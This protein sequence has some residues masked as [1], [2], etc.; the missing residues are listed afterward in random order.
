MSEPTAMELLNAINGL[1]NRLDARLAVMES[2]LTELRADNKD[3]ENRVRVVEQRTNLIDRVNALDEKI[4]R[5]RIDQ[6]N[7]IK[8]IESR[9]TQHDA[10]FS[11]A[12][13]R[14]GE[15]TI[16]LGAVKERIDASAPPKAHPVAWAAVV[17][18][19]LAIVVT[20]VSV[21]LANS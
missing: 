12:N 19:A 6:A 14:I 16:G 17:L 9:V 5:Q 7:A 8:A 20:V 13:E 2:Q 1:G 4:E 3:L 10:A 21:V 15:N 18:S 11:S